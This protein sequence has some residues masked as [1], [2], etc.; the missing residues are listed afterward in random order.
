M[1]VGGG[2]GYVGPILF[3]TFIND[4]PDNIRSS[5]CGQS[6][7]NEVQC[8]QMSLYESDSVIERLGI[9]I[10]NKFSLIIPF[11]RKLWKSSVSQIP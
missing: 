8:G 11:T 2:G 6:L 9:S 10:T 5:I 7:A 1:C 3:L 4:L